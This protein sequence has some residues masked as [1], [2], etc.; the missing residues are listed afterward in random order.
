MKPVEKPAV[1]V[2]AGTVEGR[3]LTEYLTARRIAVT[4][5]V[6]TEYGETLL[7]EK[8]N[9]YLTVHAGRMDREQI[10]AFL[11]GQEA[12]LVVDATHPYA[13]LVSKNVSAACEEAGADYVRLIRAADA[14]DTEGAVSVSS[15]EE[16]V[17][18]LKNTEG[19]ILATT[20]SKEL[21]K[22]T[23]IA[24]YESRVY[25]RVLSTAEVAAA[26]EKL[27]FR[28]KNLICMQGPFSEELNTAMLRQ[29]GC[30]Y[31]VTKETGQAG[32]FGEK[33]RA[34]RK[35]GARVVLV[36]RPREQA[37]YSYEE[38]LNILK[39]RLHIEDER[40]VD[41]IGIGMGALS[42]MTGEAREAIQ[43]A[44]LLI[45]AGRMLEAVGAGKTPDAGDTGILP[46]IAGGLQK[47]SYSA[48]DPQ[49]IADYLEA[50][51]QYVRAA[52]LLS[53]DIGFYSG[54]KKLIDVLEERGFAVRG[55]CGISSAVYF[56]GRLKTSWEDV[57]LKSAHGRNANLTAAV[58]T[59]RKT[60]A[61]LNSGES[62]RLLCRELIEYG[63]FDVRVHIGERLG[64]KEERITSGTPD[65]LKDGTY[66]PLCVV[67]I[68]NENARDHLTVGI[69]DKEFIRGKAPMTK[70]EVRALSVA[71]LRPAKDAVIYDVGA[72]TG[73]VSVELALQAPDGLICAVEQKADAC[74][75]I[76][77][78]KRKFGTP[79]IEVIQGSAPQALADLPVPACAFI[80]GSSGNLKEII[81]CLLT[82]NPHIRLVLTAVTLETLA[83]MTSCL[84]ALPL[85][86]EETLCVSV[87]RANRL[88]RYHLM[89]A[90][91]PV[92]I[93]VCRGGESG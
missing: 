64:Y 66:D 53:G 16:A 12:K 23:E 28:G 45:G 52:V 58:R 93:V 48:Y 74:A 49:K 21:Y 8:E 80:G 90:Q 34:A 91:N 82:K 61:L 71:K 62:V 56:C 63:L 30:R 31:L 87:S 13:A 81:E 3:T 32:G 6:A 75:L 44:D 33:L 1:V 78:N 10:A 51:P 54:A 14:A 70:S 36:G 35:A 27:G 50:H 2:F 9:E 89:M 73:S 88:G 24:D 67:L 19:N 37:G 38:V 69:A 68:V 65:E 18:Y 57:C 76:E 42:G 25:A 11:A 83:E 43:N 29:F 59:H 47:P 79:N 39:E 60:F 17:E 20:G 72:G 26:C 40:T 7:E 46:G 55:V 22:Y 86:E 5:C 85:I 77:E 41:L 84:Q 92:Y 4:A 15:V